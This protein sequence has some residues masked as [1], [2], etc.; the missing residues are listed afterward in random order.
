MEKSRRTQLQSEKKALVA[1]FNFLY[2]NPKLSEDDLETI[3]EELKEVVERL[4]AKL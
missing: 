2:Q 4:K 1:E 3:K